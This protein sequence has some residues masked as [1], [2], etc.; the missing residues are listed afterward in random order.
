ML[1]EWGARRLAYQIPMFTEG[2]DRIYRVTLPSTAP[3]AIEAALHQR[4]NVNVVGLALTSWLT[5]EEKAAERPIRQDV[6][7]GQPRKGGVL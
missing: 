4:A 3:K 7:F 1:D 2:H 5:G 6:A